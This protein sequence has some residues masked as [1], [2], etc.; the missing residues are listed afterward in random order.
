MAKNSNSIN[1]DEKLKKYI[2][3]ITSSLNV[4]KINKCFTELDKKNLIKIL[5]MLAD[6]FNPKYNQGGVAGW[7]NYFMRKFGSYNLGQ[8]TPNPIQNYLNSLPSTNNIYNY[9]NY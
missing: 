1:I 5:N 8:N 3:E 2:H 6:T 4:D 7:R 9:V